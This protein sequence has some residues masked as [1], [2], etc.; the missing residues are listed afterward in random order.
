LNFLR[1]QRGLSS[2]PTGVANYR[3]QRETMLNLLADTVE[4]HLDLSPFLPSQKAK[5]EG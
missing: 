2:L 4:E 3:E 1:Q 5:Q